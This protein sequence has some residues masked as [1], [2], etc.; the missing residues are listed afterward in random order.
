MLKVGINWLSPYTLPTVR[1]LLDEGV[2]DFCE[3][4]VD[5]AVHLPAAKIRAALGDAPVAL[6]IVTSNFLTKSSAELQDMARH[7]R[8]WMS[9]LQPLYVSDHLSQL[10][11][12]ADFET[13]CE[14]VSEW[15]ELLG[16]KLLL[17]NLPSMSAAGAGQ[18]EFYARLMQETGC[19]LLFDFS[20][21][22]IA[23]YNLSLL[24]SRRKP[25]SSNKSAFSEWYPLI[26]KAKHFHVAG[27]RIDPATQLATDTHDTPISE[28][29]FAMMRAHF[30]YLPGVR[31]RTIVFELD[32]NLDYELA[33]QQILRLKGG[34]VVPAKAGTQEA[35]T[36]GSRLSSGRQRHPGYDFV[37][38]WSLRGLDH[39]AAKGIIMRIK[40]H[41]DLAIGLWKSTEPDQPH[42]IASLDI[43]AAK[44]S[45]ADAY[46]ISYKTGSWEGVEWTKVT[47][48]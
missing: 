24:S 2:A 43:S 48:Y 40:T 11:Y 38:E 22:Y 1:R 9:E 37:T 19:D 7:L 45:P 8:P 32:T 44:L 46:A 10:D 3:I 15:Q 4:M 16:T 12:Q 18:A 14:R 41:P 26:E 17:E 27:Y 23:E 20:N 34:P 36:T 39:I 6:H 25:G 5:N 31:E 47:D 29:V 42:K 33:K 21:A 30:S 35:A 28:E 13:T